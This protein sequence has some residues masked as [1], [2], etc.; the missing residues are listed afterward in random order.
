MILRALRVSVVIVGYALGGD[1]RKPQTDAECD[2][3]AECPFG[4][5]SQCAPCLG[6]ELDDVEP[7]TRLE[8]VTC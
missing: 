1:S 6:G 5:D 7:A 4:S 3:W 8:L 2:R